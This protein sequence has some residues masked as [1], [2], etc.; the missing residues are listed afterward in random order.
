TLLEVLAEIHRLDRG[1]ALRFFSG[2]RTW[3]LTYAELY[4]NIGVFAGYLDRAGLR[5]GDRAIIWAENR[6]EW[7]SAF[8]GC[9]ARGVQVVPVDYRSSNDLV[10]RI[11]SEVHARLIVTGDSV[12][13]EGL[14]VP[15]LPVSG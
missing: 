7:V 1:E 8:W 13:C 2:F 3:R 15:Q 9:V 4:R 11:Q 5:K 14:D 12:A 6:P 10:K